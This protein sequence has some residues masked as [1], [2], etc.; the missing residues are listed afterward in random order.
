M[1]GFNGLNQV[2]EIIDPEIS[3][4]LTLHNFSHPFSIYFDFF[5]FT[6]NNKDKQTILC[7]ADGQGRLSDREKINLQSSFCLLFMPKWGLSLLVCVW[8]TQLR[9]LNVATLCPI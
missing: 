7:K 8:A 6:R 4:V 2:F 3:Q 9:A 5:L 1:Y